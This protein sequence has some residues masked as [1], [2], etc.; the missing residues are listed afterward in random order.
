MKQLACGFILFELDSG[1]QSRE[2]GCQGVLPC[3]RGQ[4]LAP[5]QETERGSAEEGQNHS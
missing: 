5:N 4:K 3:Y 1:G 2:Q